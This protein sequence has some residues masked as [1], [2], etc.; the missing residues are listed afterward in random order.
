MK[1]FTRK[2]IRKQKNGNG[3]YKIYNR[4]KKLLYVGRASNGN[5]K[6]HLTQHFGSKKYSGAKIKGKRKNHFFNISITTPKGARKLEK[7][8]IRKHKP[9]K[10]TYKYKR[11]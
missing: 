9:R 10:N 2:N 1:K 6:H 7:K 5:V 3:I 4:C 8:L 11:K